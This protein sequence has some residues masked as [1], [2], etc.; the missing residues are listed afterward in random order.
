VRAVLVG[1]C[2]ASAW[3][4]DAQIP[5]QTTNATR[6]AKASPDE[7]YTALGQNVKDDVPPCRPDQTLKVNQ[8]YAWSVVDTGDDV[9]IGTTANALCTTEG[10]VSEGDIGTT[11][12]QTPGWACEYGASPYSPRP[13]PNALGDMRPP[14]I[15][16]YNKASK[17]L[18]DITPRSGGPRA[19]RL[20]PLLQQ[21]TGLRAATMIGSHVVFAGPQ[22]T[23][24]LAFFAF[25]IA[26][27]RWV[28]KGELNGYNNIRSF[29]TVDGVVYAG[30]GKSTTGG[31][32]LRY[33]G[34][35]AAIPAPLVGERVGRCPECFA[36]DTV[37]ALDSDAAYLA[38]HN[39]RL[40]VSTWPNGGL[41]GLY[42]GTPV[43]AGGYTTAHQ[44]QWTKV[45]DANQYD[46]DPV[47]A[48]SYAGG[49]L[50][51]FGGYLYWGTINVPFKSF[52]AWVD[53]YGPPA[54]ADEAK[55]VV[56][57]TFR[58]AAVFRSPGFDTPTPQVDLLYGAARLLAYTPP[59]QGGTGGSWALTTNKMPAGSTNPLYGGSGFGNLYN[60]YIWSM[61]VWQNKLWVG[62][63][64]WSWVVAQTEGL[65]TPPESTVAAQA[66]PPAELYGADL[67]VFSDTNSAAVAED[68]NGLG[69]ITSYGVRNLVPAGDSMYVGI[70]NAA[71]LLGDPANPPNGGWELIQLQPK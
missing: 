33:R 58:T 4:A 40:Y 10:A 30:V 24:G 3:P 47:V 13:Y 35:F 61:A 70:A 15:Y 5:L 18:T 55:R 22:L 2:V 62:T 34:S 67:F 25:E 37:G 14:R 21:T 66:A 1:L 8:S 29:L 71:N 46:P 57:Q 23:G 36:F 41:G 16:V 63:F 56:A 26:S 54:T 38:V 31:S 12:Y 52:F 64:D 65:F 53:A 27:K 48:T 39:G 43:P 20:D 69:N 19:T 45:W 60:I 59:P 11:P 7:C 51:S 68:T 32:I 9:W 49:A 50:K 44:N 42:M 17:V 6:L 28:A